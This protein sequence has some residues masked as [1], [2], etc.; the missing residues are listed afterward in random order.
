[1]SIQEEKV[2]V[3][4]NFFDPSRECSAHTARARSN[5]LR[6]TDIREKK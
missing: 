2:K 3:E 1:M 5:F 6:G 4:K